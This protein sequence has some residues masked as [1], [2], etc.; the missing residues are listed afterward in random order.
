ME[1][2]EDEDDDADW[3][4]SARWC[5]ASY[6]IGR[7]GTSNNFWAYKKFR[8]AKYDAYNLLVGY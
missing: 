3:D 1:Q 2:D 5:T 4:V 6:T 8:D 7:T